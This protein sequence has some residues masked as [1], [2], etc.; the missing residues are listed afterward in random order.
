MNKIAVLRLGHRVPRDGR[1]TSHVALV[2]RAYG[3][4]GI[5]ISGQRDEGLL[6]TINDVVRRWGGPFWAQYRH[7]WRSV[8]NQW[9]LKGALILHLTAYGINLPEVIEK[10]RKEY[11][12][13]DI[14]IIV[15]SKKVPAEVFKLAD[16][17]VAV[18]NQPHSE[19]AALATLLDWIFQGKELSKEFK[20]PEIAIVPQERG[21][22]VVEVKKS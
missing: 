19:V 15:G 12:L 14:L 4:D 20:D 1:V 3:A 11:E 5:I 10:I 18:S 7:D 2:A 21:K 17:N 6:I 16:I 13:R 8:I 22:K 9:K